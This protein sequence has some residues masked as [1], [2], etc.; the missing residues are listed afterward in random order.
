MDEG[1]ASKAGKRRLERTLEPSFHVNFI[2]HCRS[3]RCT[4]ISFARERERERRRIDQL[5]GKVSMSGNERCIGALEIEIAR[6][7]VNDGKKEKK[8]REGETSIFWINR[9]RKIERNEK[10]GIR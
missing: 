3:F 7:N 9:D 2:R 6:Q 10:L 1:G 8:K 4:T 5:E